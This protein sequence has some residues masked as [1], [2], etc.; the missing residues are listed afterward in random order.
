MVENRVCDDVA[1]ASTTPALT[2]AELNRYDVHRPAQ[3]GSDQ[4]QQSKA[5]VQKEVSPA[6]RGAR[7]Q[8]HRLSIELGLECS[9][10]S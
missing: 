3:V 7:A 2:A 10:E 4:R 1:L 8:V 5:D 9:P 6:C